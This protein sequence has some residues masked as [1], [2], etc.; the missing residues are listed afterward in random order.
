M[1]DKKA[2]VYTALGF[3]II[4]INPKYTQFRGEKILDVNPKKLMRE[5][6]KAVLKKKA[7]LSGAEIKFLR[8]YLK[9][10]QQ[11][12]ADLVEIDRTSVTKWEAKKHSFTGMDHHTEAYL[13]ACCASRF[14]LTSS[15]SEESITQ[16]VKTI[17]AT[18][19]IGEPISI[20]APAA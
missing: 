10:T 1:A 14:G 19:E 9:L 17:R 11:E 7:R 18:D 16:S 5:A 8:T 12:F 15:F 3:P 13:R 2:P 4:I 6:F 20:R